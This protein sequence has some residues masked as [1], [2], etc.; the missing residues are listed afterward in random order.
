MKSY[1]MFILLHGIS[2]INSVSRLEDSDEVNRS[3]YQ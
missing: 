2:F 1:D 3:I